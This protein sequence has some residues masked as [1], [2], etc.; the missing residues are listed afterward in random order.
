MSSNTVIG[1]SSPSGGNESVVRYYN[2]NYWYEKY[3]CDKKVEYKEI[4][5]QLGNIT[6]RIEKLNI[7]RFLNLKYEE[8]KDKL[9]S[10]IGYCFRGHTF[11]LSCIKND[12]KK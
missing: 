10:D 2:D 12:L 8:D 7:K 11:D 6:E 4:F 9:F 5:D 3:F 1:L